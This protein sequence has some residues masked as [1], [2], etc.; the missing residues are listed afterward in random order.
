MTTLIELPLATEL[1]QNTLAWQ[2]TVAQHQKFEQFYRAMVAA[3]LQF[4]L[5]RITDAS[6]FWEKHLWDALS[7]I[8]PW[9]THPDVAAPFKVVDIGSGAGVPGV[10][11]AIAQPNWQI[12]LLEARRKK[13]NFLDS[14][15]ELL[16]IGNITPVWK[17]AEDYYPQASFDVALLRA[18]GNIDQCLGYALPLTR[19][20]GMVILYRGHFQTHESQALERLLQTSGASLERVL[21]LQTPFTGSQRHCLF[22]RRPGPEPIP[23]PE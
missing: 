7:G 14:L 4:N 10:P 1:W 2:P 9:L 21:S 19:P 15:P 11:V 8:Q 18:V 5:T 16:D 20:G 23:L 3:N 22:I 6:D 17:R 13:V 12:T